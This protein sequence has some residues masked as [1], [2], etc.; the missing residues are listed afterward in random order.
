MNTVK[1]KAYA[2]Q[3]RKDFIKAVT[4]RANIYGIFSD[5]HVEP[6]EFKGDLA[7]IGDRAFTKKEGELR[8][9]L[10]SCVKKD[11]FE[12][13]MRAY[14]YTWFNRFV[15][16]RYMELHNYLDHGRRVLSNPGE[17]DIP[18]ILEL[19]ANVD[20]QGLDKNKV[21][22]LRLAGNKDNELYRLLI[23]AQCNT[24]HDAMPFLF[25]RVDSETELL[26]PDNLLHSDS[27]IRKMVT[28]I[29]EEDWNDVEI[30]GWIYQFY[31]SERKNEVIGKVV[32]SEDIP[33]ATQLFTPNWIV[34]YMVQNTLGR[35]WLATYPDSSLKE[36]MEYY[37]EPVEQEPEVQKQI[38]KITP[39]E[40]NPEEITFLDPAS[41]SGHILV[42]AYDILKEI[43]LERGY[44]TRDIP[45]LI[46]EKNLYGLDIDDR[47]AQLACFAVL[48]RARRDDRRILSRSDI[49]LDITAIQ[50]TGR[51]DTEALTKNLLKEKVIR[52]TGENELFPDFKGQMALRTIKRP[53]VSRDDVIELI[54]L[55]HH[56]KTFG[57]LVTIP[58]SL[59]EKLPLFASLIEDK[60]KNG[61][62]FER[63]AAS[64]LKPVVEMA[65]TLARK[66]DCVVTNPPY[67]G[68]K[69]LNGQLKTFLK[70]NYTDAKSDLFSAFIVR[71][72]VL[73]KPEGQ[74]GYMSPFV[75]LFISSYEKLRSFLI[76]QKTITSLIQ[77]EYSGFD[78]ATV[79]ICTLTVL[80]AYHPNFKGGYI[81]LSDFRG[82]E[83]QGPKTLEAIHNQSCGW[84]YRASS[85]DFKKIPGGPIAYWISDSI[86][87]RF[88]TEPTIS[89]TG[90]A[91][92][93][94]QTGN[95]DLFLRR[96]WEV[97]YI[98]TGFGFATRKHAAET[99]FKWFPCSKGGGFRKW[100][101]NN[102]YTV[103]WLNDGKDIKQK[104]A[105]DLAKGKI[106][107]NNSKC[108][109]Q[110]Y[111]FRCGIGWNMITSSSPSFRLYEDGII[112]DISSPTLFVK[113][114]RDIYGLLAYFNS[115]ICGVIAFALSPTLNFVPGVLSQ[116]PKPTKYE[117]KATT[118]IGKTCVDISQSDWNSLETSWDFTNLPLLYADYHR[119]A[120]KA[121]YASL[122]TKWYEITLKMQQ[123][124][125]EN[126]QIFIN[127]YSLQDELKP[128]VRLDKITLACNPYYRYG[129]NKTEEELETLLLTD[130]I[131]ELISYSIGCMMGRYSLD[132]PGLIYAH[133]GNEEFNP[134]K[135]K[136]F[137]A[138][139]DGIIPVM[140]VDWFD[141]DATN[142][143]IEFI[144]VAWSSET[145]GENLKFIADSLKPKNNDVPINTIRRYLSVG[146][147]KDH[148]KTYKKRPIYWLFSSGKQKAFECLVYLHR[149]NESTLSR[150][151]SSYVTPLQGNFSARMEFLQKEKDAVTTASAQKKIQKE[152]DV[153]K[154]KQ[155]EL[156]AFDDELRHFADMKIPL[157][158]D[159]GVKVNYGKFGNLLAE[160]K[161]IT[162]KNKYVDMLIS[163]QI[164]YNLQ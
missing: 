135:Y 94:L 68:G 76:N 141:D 110:E 114:E 81:R 37:I 49:K 154:K 57:S 44:R 128:D 55:F 17:S 130:T 31:I 160:K 155:T 122:R 127:E 73:A 29:D 97:S 24:L 12:H 30:I 23:V 82:A 125:K 157:D 138:D 48:M 15:A 153:I 129:D 32:K 3:A 72:T 118:L 78:G 35:M 148:L 145:L 158:L 8:E 161:A 119:P 70:D 61:D 54:E 106:T 50:E 69:G 142:R 149:Y 74:I 59:S 102:E 109:N 85:I 140:D 1:I 101:G 89:S 63:T 27:T 52:F 75:W 11:G 112:F 104:K 96:W 22:E 156:S 10:V 103:N 66:Y 53:E 147:F 2:P 105:N 77:L 60:L 6:I 65:M 21:I 151:R 36:K 113:N 71:N 45:R 92:T 67:M 38:D 100:Y 126:N 150:M 116:F 131:K 132:Q 164:V 14:A 87:N 34:K 99:E 111:Y 79:P 162:G 51:L 115:K 9:K 83:N 159:D 18:E 152:I 47:A 26:L 62:M 7:I 95:T 90:K 143:F 163:R 13:V 40:L 39:K 108:W 91:L 64:K 133:S 146:F 84:F 107:A 4:Q 20:F 5:D 43:Y 93:G 117:L 134:S 25:E 88:A 42:E 86:R 139:D 136:S 58:E 137:P 123:L 28:E 121:A 33:A 16:L 124:E 19:A 98:A 56:G 41:G 46:L 120:L 144:K 80:N